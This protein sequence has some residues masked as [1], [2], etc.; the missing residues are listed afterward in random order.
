[1]RL[2]VE[3]GGSSG[4]QHSWDVDVS[5][6]CMS[7]L[8]VPRQKYYL[9]LKKYLFIYLYLRLERVSE[10]I[11]DSIFLGNKLSMKREKN[12][13]IFF[14]IFP[15]FYFIGDQG[16]QLKHYKLISFYITVILI[17]KSL[18]SIFQKESSFLLKVPNRNPQTQTR[19][20][21]RYKICVNSLDCMYKFF[22]L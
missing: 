10:N 2:A 7:F 20:I 9:R 15:Q 22:P 12:K 17:S 19:K 21:K 14:N 3:D 8:L 6:W 4:C 16:S 5:P 1:L 13:T 11:G 18:F